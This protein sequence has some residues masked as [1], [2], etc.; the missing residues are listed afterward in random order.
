MAFLI[1][2]Q[3]HA[4]TTATFRFV[5][6]VDG[7]PLG[8]F[9]KCTLPTLELDVEEVKE[10]G[11]NSYIHQLPGQRK[12]TKII[13]E[14]GL[15]IAPDLIAWYIKTMQGDFRRRNVTITLLNSLMVPIMVWTAQGAYPS[16]WSGPDL[17]T[18]DDTV[19][20]QTLELVCNEVVVV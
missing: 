4:L 6:A 16:K 10:G 3:L 19:A 17:R 1:D 15:G 18:Q 13:L 8:A 2:Q 11:L 7:V 12:A 9:T 14:N 5:V 20:L